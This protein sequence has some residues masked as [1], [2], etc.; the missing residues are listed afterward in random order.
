MT[1]SLLL[2]TLFLEF[3]DIKLTIINKLCYITVREKKAKTFALHVC[4]CVCRCLYF[5]G[6]HE[7]GFR[8][9][10]VGPFFSGSF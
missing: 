3:S 5:F 10:L 1:I 7:Q 8:W 2:H 9:D 4:V 6:F